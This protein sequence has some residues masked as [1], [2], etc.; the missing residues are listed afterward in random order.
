MNRVFT[1]LAALSAG[2]AGPVV[3]AS[4]AMAAPCPVPAPCHP[5]PPVTATG[6]CAQK[7]G[8]GLQEPFAAGLFTWRECVTGSPSSPSSCDLAAGSAGTQA[9]QL[10]YGA[11]GRPRRTGPCGQRIPEA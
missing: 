8:D 9:S 5:V 1:R 11:P 3:L 7:A 2:L 10:F 6:R 4:A